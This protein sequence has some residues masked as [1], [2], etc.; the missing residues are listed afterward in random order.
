MTFDGSLIIDSLPR[1]MDGL[2]ITLRLYVL[3]LTCGTTLAI[4]L[5][6][7]RISSKKYLSWPVMGY[8]Y[9]FRGTP[10]LV[11]LFI[12]YYGLPQLEF[13]RTGPLWT[14][15]REPFFCAWF[16]LT[17][18]VAAYTAEIFR[19]GILG[20]NS[21]LVEASKALGMTY[22]QTFRKVTAP[23]AFKLSLPAYSNEMISVLKATA[24]ASTVTIFD[25]TGVARKIVAETFAPYEIFLSAAIIYLVLAWVIQNG[26]RHLERRISRYAN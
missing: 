16:A 5:V 18:N 17:L 23:I 8:I 20:V 13:I 14:F 21:G 26:V 1:L 22:T 19:G 7:M 12:I 4:A 3:A 24:L 2:W 9:F 25:V 15:F 10:I 11:Q 6:L